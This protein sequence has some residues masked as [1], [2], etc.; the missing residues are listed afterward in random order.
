[1]TLQQRR[2]VLAIAAPLIF[3]L[4]SLTFGRNTNWDLRNYHW[5]NPYAWLT[6]RYQ[7]DIAPAGGAEVEIATP[8]GRRRM[9]L[10]G[11]YVEDGRAHLTLAEDELIVAAHLP[12]D[13]PPSAYAKV[14]VRGAIDYPLAGVAVALALDDGIVKS[15]SIGLT[16]TNSRP[17]V[18]AGTEALVGRP[19]DEAAL[20][21]IDRFVQKQVQPMRT[22]NTSAHYR[23]LAAAALARRLTAALVAGPQPDPSRRSERA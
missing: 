2:A 3:G 7:I 9:P 8:R 11:I 16:G 5:Y 18:L 19:I 10:G 14:R 17:F 22:T 21:T 6:D 23:R 1:M 13:S 12:P 4:A 20:L 15:L